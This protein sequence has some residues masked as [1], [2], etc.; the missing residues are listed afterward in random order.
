MVLRMMSVVV[1]VVYTYPTTDSPLGTP[2]T[3]GNLQ[4]KHHAS[5]PPSA[6]TYIPYL[7]LPTVHIPNVDTSHQT[8]STRS[9][10]IAVDVVVSVTIPYIYTVLLNTTLVPYL[11]L[12]FYW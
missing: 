5:P 3:I 1:I 4:V 7:H 9:G 6:L 11:L 12:R 2:G 8:T 10:S